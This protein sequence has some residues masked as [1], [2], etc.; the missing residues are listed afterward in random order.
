MSGQW[1]DLKLLPPSRSQGASFVARYQLE[2]EVLGAP[3]GQCS[4]LDWALEQYAL[5]HS[6]VLNARRE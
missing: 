5:K 6:S 4:E 1:K 3:G 2:K